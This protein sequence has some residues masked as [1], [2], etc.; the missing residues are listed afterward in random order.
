MASRAQKIRLTAFAVVTAL[1]V[2]TVLVVFAGIHFWEERTD[3]RVDFEGTVLGLEIGA[4]V[5]V[6]GLR[7]GSVKSME[8]APADIR[9]VRVGIEVDA[10][11]PVCGDTRA[12]LVFQGITGLKIIDL[13]GGTSA[14]ARLPA[15]STIAAGL[16][17][18]DRLE[19]K[20]DRIVDRS[21]RLMDNL[22][23]LTDPR[24][25][26]GVERIVAQAIVTAD[27]L[28]RTTR[29]L[30]A[31]VR[32]TRI[33][34]RES[35]AAVSHAANSLSDLLDNQLAQL[36]GDAGTLVGDLRGAVRANQ[37]E[38]RAALGD[39]RQ[40]SRSFKELARELR[41]RP[42]R[43]LFSKASEDRKLP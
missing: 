42:S 20:A 9:N 18:L 15:G 11:A 41:Q 3:Y 31:L 38:V 14:A 27:A 8:L 32:E 6:N 21:T 17:S 37:I 26:A 12:F 22:V 28:T 29:E 4:P 2:I 35:F 34:A 24:R 30:D 7:V 16:G 23:E 43:L 36:A 40:A 39:L 1:L 33:A 19:A 13:R 5:L 25:F 10:N